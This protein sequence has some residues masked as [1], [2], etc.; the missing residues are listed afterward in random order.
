MSDIPISVQMTVA[1]SE[2][3]YNMTVES[4]INVDHFL[5]NN[6]IVNGDFSVPGATTDGWTAL[7]SKSSLSVANGRL[8]LTHNTTGNG[9]Y[10][11]SCAV[12]TIA[13]HTY[14]LKFKY[15]KTLADATASRIV[16]IRLGGLDGELVNR[17]PDLQPNDIVENVTAITASANSSSVVFMFG[18]NIGLTAS[19][20]S[21]LELY[22]FEMYDVTDYS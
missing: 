13:G 12:D 3:A 2:A 11:I 14:F 8:V 1:E 19:N 7:N 20:D 22:Y 6:L 15:K 10:S 18:G 16:D 4:E 9:R 21:M 17:K 5:E